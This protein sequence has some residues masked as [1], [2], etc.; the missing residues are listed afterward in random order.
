[1]NVF[2]LAEV[3]DKSDYHAPNTRAATY[4]VPPP[5]YIGDVRYTVPN[6]SIPNTYVL[7]INPVVKLGEIPVRCTC[8]YCRALI[9]THVKRTPGLLVWILCFIL[10]LFGC[11]LGCCLIPFC[12]RDLQNVQ[13]YCPNCK[14][15]IGEYR[16]I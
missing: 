8:G 2:L 3:I 11:W 16:I 6:E 7:Q 4:A 9:V 13:H 5:E 15:F 12:I 14:G 1:M 10:I